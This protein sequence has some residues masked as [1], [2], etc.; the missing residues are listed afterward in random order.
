[1]SPPPLDIASFNIR[2]WNRRDGP[3]RWRFRRD[4]VARVVRRTDVAGLQEVRR[5]QLR[6]LHWGAPG[7]RW[8]GVGRRDG[9]SGGEHV[10][11]FWRE[12]RLRCVDHGDFW[13]SS[14]PDVPGSRDHED[15]IT[16]M[17]TWARFEDRVGVRRRILVVNTHL[18]HRSEAAR[19]D[20]ARQ[21]RA[22]VA[23]QAGRDAVLVTADLNCTPDSEPYEVL[24]GSGHGPTLADARAQAEV[25]SGPEATLNG[26]GRARRPRRIDV[27]LVSPH[28]TVLSHRTDA[29]PRPRARSVSPD[30]AFASDHHPVL[31]RARLS[32]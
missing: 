2:F 11:V 24:V 30:P 19:I 7:R 9:G 22:F 8:V 10:P 32:S 1:M 20:A 25:V 5:P 4:A 17:A 6:D 3:D 28:W 23:G 31:V 15:A 29:R 26:F 12:A 27:V 16:R 14:T 13:L 18:D 21:I